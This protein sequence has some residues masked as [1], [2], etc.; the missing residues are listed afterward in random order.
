MASTANGI[1]AHV[2]FGPFVKGGKVRGKYLG[3]FSFCGTIKDTRYVQVP[4]SPKELTIDLDTPISV[5]GAERKTLLIYINDDGTGS[6]Y[7]N[8]SHLA[9]Q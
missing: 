5:F 1:V 9:P 6:K 2:S 4:G 8:D 3:K 7:G